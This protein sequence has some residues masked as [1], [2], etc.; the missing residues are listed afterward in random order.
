MS[1]IKKISAFAFVLFILKAVY[2][3]EG[4]FNPKVFKSAS[5]FRLPSTNSDLNNYRV[6]HPAL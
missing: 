4:I 1:L 2:T 5:S 6:F 3:A